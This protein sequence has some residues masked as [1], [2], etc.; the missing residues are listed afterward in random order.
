VTALRAYRLIAPSLGGLLLALIVVV[1]VQLVLDLTVVLIPVALFLLVRWSLLG[2][3]LG[4]EHGSGL[5]ALGRSGAVTRG[6][7]WRTATV[8]LGISGLALLAG[9]AVGVLTLLFTGAAFDLVNLIA[10][11]VYVAALP[12]AAIV[13]TYLYFDL[14]ARQEAAAV[15]EASGGEVSATT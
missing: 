14:S 4:V 3:V 12:F 6:Y 11:L 7:W 2:V 1:P 5:A 13:T 10:A 8:V 9:P 15:E